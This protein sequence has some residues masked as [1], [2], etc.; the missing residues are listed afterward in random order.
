MDTTR[1][2]RREAATATAEALGNGARAERLDSQGSSISPDRAST[3]RGRI[4]VRP[5]RSVTRSLRVRE[6]RGIGAGIAGKPAEL[7][8]TG[9]IAELDELERNS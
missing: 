7:V 1:G 4:G 6:L 9:T 8:E 3:P 2:P 5:R